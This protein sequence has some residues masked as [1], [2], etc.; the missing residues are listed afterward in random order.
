[1]NHNNNKIISSHK[2]HLI[3]PKMDN[4]NWIRIH[5]LAK[6]APFLTLLMIGQISRTVSARCAQSKMK[7]LEW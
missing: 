1:M 2:H 5:G 4:N 6:I 7:V 3:L